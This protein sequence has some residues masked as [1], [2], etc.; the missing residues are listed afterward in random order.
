MV[1]RLVGR[2]DVAVGAKFFY[3]R[4]KKR[5]CKNVSGVVGI[6]QKK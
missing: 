6:V 1:L 5:K 2:T 4:E 3:S